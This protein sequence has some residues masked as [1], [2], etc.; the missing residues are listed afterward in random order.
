LAQGRIIYQRKNKEK[1]KNITKHAKITLILTLF[2]GWGLLA[3]AQGPPPPPPGGGHGATGNQPAGGEAP[4]G[5]GI[6]ILLT[7]GAA[8]GGRK[9]YQAYKGVENRE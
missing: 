9:V 2:M 3:M 5:G 6:A 7:L 4:I 1:M 8:W